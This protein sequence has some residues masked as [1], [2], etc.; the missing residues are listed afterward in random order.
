LQDNVHII[1]R[2]SESNEKH[3]ALLGL[4]AESQ[5]CSWNMQFNSQPQSFFQLLAMFKQ[6]GNCGFP[7]KTSYDLLI[8]SQLQDLSFLS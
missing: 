7:A 1:E 2:L 5:N 3:E 4:V 6:A 8:K